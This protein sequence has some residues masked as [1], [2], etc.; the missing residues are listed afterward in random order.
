MT[1]HG[2]EERLN[3]A[4]M[5]FDVVT[6][7]GSTWLGT[8]RSSGTTGPALR[9]AAEFG[10]PVVGRALLPVNPFATGKSARPTGMF[11]S[12]RHHSTGFPGVAGFPDRQT[13]YGL[14]RIE[15]SSV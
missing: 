2:S 15:N 3:G 12:A 13:V 4:P 5:H 6:W 11:P 7:H 1:R 14:D 10:S 8:T 9:R